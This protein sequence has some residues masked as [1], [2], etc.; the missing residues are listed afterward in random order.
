MIID[1]K[2]GLNEVDLSY[3]E[4]TAG[5]DAPEYNIYGN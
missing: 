3:Y 2:S 5:A 4:G 1:K